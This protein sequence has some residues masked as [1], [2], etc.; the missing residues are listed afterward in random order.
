MTE[1]IEEDA[2]SSDFDVGAVRADFPI[3]NTVVDGHPLVYLDNAATSQKPQVVIDAISNY[4]VAQNANIHRG[5]HYLSERATDAYEAARE[6]IGRFIN[7]TDAAEIVFV[8]GTTE[9]ISLVAH[10]FGRR[11]IQVGDEIVISAVEHH[12]NIVPWQMVADERGATLKVIPI[13]DEGVLN[14][15]AYAGLL[16]E[17]TKM[18]AVTH[19]S[20]AL[21]IINPIAEMSRMAHEKNVPV[22]IDGAQSAPHLKV[23][24]KELDCD[25]FVFSGHKTYGPTGIGV[26]YGKKKWLNEI[27]PYLGGG[28]TIRSV[29]FEETRFLDS[30]GKFEAGTPNIAGAIALGVALDYVENIGLENIEVYERELYAYAVNALT[31][32]DD[33]RIF[34]RAPSMAGVVSFLVGDVHAHDISTFLNAEGIAVRAGHHCAQPL[35]KRLGISGTARASFSFYNT[36]EEVDRL[37]A[38]LRNISE[39]FSR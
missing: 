10:S 39:F 4:Y 18:V 11:Y 36:Q 33:V 8:R 17:R 25:F 34:G 6:E 16:N 2:I 38:G 3:L 9:G 20:N 7:A 21:G 14:L 30:P 5:I 32:L 13:D 31:D 28:G 19:V 26:L 27:P 12:S 37:V 22:L 23:D 29:N 15:E 35:M 24:V 1:I